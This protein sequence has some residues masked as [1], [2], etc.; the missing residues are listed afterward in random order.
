[1]ILIKNKSSPVHININSDEED[2]KSIKN[3]HD[4]IKENVEQFEREELLEGE[5]NFLGEFII[6]TR[7]GLM[8]FLK[9][10]CIFNSEFR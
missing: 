3:E 4:I 1:M 10:V 5:E 6:K 7:T 2:M 8:E 9:K